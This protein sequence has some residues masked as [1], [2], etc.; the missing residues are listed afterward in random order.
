M[1]Y[2]FLLAVNMPGSGNV[3]HR[4]RQIAD[5]EP[6]ANTNDLLPGD[7]FAGDASVAGK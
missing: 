4:D 2:C 7:L 6:T 5:V 3:I 1:T